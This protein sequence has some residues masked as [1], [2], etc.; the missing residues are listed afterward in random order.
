MLRSAISV[1]ALGL[2]ALAACTPSTAEDDG[3][4]GG[5]GGGSGPLSADTRKGAVYGSTLSGD[6]TVNNVTYDDAT[7]E[8]I[9]NNIPFDGVD[10]RYGFE[11]FLAATDFS[12]YENIEG[13]NSYYAVFR[14]SDSG[15]SQVAALA[16]DSYLDYGPGGAQM[17]R[18]NSSTRLPSSGEYFYFGDYA[19]V[20]AFEKGDAV[21]YVTGDVW[22]EVDIE[23]FDVGGAVEGGVDSIQFY[24]S[25]GTLIGN[26]DHY[27]TI[28][29]T[30]IDF[31]NAT[32][33]GGTANMRKINPG[34]DDDGEILVAGTWT[35]MFTGP[36]AEELVGI[37]LFTGPENLD[38]EARTMRETGV[39]ITFAD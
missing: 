32:V 9:I 14:R 17:L 34:E 30:S 10:G 3:G 36:D 7:G 39:M 21:E 1:S 8:L 13:T 27:I 33:P 37:F 15:Y 26:A 28:P 18:R 20:R 19:A 5:G 6:L 22:I 4:G 24:T 25:S 35:G 38:D 23:D 12:R 31:S 11:G 29:T 16:T 2:A